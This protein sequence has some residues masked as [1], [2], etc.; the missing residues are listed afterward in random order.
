MPVALAG[1][2]SP[3]FDEHARGTLTPDADL[4]ASRDEFIAELMSALAREDGGQ[5]LEA[6]MRIGCARGFE[7]FPGLGACM[8]ANGF[9]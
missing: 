9:E 2:R 5:R 4:P 8:H 1:E 7:P 6:L 3:A